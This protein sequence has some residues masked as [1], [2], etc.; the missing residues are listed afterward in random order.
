M[1]KFIRGPTAREDAEGTEMPGS[2]ERELERNAVPAEKAKQ[3][4]RVQ[5]VLVCR[6]HLADDAAVVFSVFAP[7]DFPLDL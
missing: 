5:G 6:A 1:T 3:K 2:R 4:L 7:Q